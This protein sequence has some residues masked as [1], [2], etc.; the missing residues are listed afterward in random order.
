MSVAAERNSL[1]GG[2]C[3]DASNELALQLVRCEHCRIGAGF[4]E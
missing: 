2:F 1:A 4:T 3:L